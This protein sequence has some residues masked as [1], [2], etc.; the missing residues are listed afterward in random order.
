MSTQST[1]RRY[2]ISDWMIAVSHYV[3]DVRPRFRTQ[4]A[5]RTEL[6][7]QVKDSAAQ[8]RARHGTCG[9]VKRTPDSYEVRIGSRDG[10]HTWAQFRIN[11]ET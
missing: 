3:A 5:A 11:Q 9:V 10:V 1:H 6:R 8:C 7:A 4:T 2:V